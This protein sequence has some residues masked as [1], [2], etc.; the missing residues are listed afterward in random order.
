MANLE[1]FSRLVKR[2]GHWYSNLKKD[3]EELKDIAIV[4]ASRTRL[5]NIVN[6][7]EI[8]KNKKYIIGKNEWDIDAITQYLKNEGNVL[9]DKELTVEKVKQD[10][11]TEKYVI[12]SKQEYTY[13]E[14]EI[15]NKNLCDWL[16]VNKYSFTSIEGSYIENG[17]SEDAETIEKSFFVVNVRNNPDFLTDIAKIS[18][19]YN[20]DSFFFKAAQDD[21]VFLIGTNNAK[22]LDYHEIKSAGKL[23]LK[24]EITGDD[25]GN[26][27]SKVGKDKFACQNVD[28]NKTIQDNNIEYLNKHNC[29][30]C[31]KSYGDYLDSAFVWENLQVNTKG[32]L[33]RKVSPIDYII[34]KNRNW[35]W[36]DEMRNNIDV[37]DD[38]EFLYERFVYEDYND[39]LNRVET[40][41]PGSN[42][43]TK[44]FLN[45]FYNGDIKQWV[46][47]NKDN[48]LCFNCKNCVDCKNCN[49]CFDCINC[50]FCEDCENCNN[51]KRSKKCIECVKCDRCENCENLEKMYMYHDNAKYIY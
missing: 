23:R 4:T 35:D 19:Y 8:L 50:R 1:A 38:V 48:M 45:E 47:E 42:G 51:C 33:S 9:I 36:L 29:Y 20:Q 41:N 15:R 31:K 49:E 21:E 12:Q 32:Y 43:V 40:H 5:T 7:D 22:N 44:E 6:N 3:K 25:K 24:K 30:R 46:L 11:G 28:L 34:D 26:G 13:K 2:M 14:I 39:F 27:C 18:E 16:R 10:D 37:F 17:Q